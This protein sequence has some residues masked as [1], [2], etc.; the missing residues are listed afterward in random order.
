MT[1]QLPKISVAETLAAK[2]IALKPGTLPLATTL[3]CEDIR[4]TAIR[5]HW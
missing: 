1:S 2:I 3:K 4:R 5:I